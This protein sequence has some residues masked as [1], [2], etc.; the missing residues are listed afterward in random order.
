M[1]AN[2]K[3][4]PTRVP[5]LLHEQE[6]DRGGGGGEKRGML[7]RAEIRRRWIGGTQKGFENTSRAIFTSA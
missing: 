7:K 6:R 5:G 4:E 1:M 2:I 3:I